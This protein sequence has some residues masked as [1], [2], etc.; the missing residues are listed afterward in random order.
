MR[1]PKRLFGPAYLTTSPAT[2]YGP[3]ASGRRAIVRFIQ[4]QVNSG[5]SS[6]FRLSIGADAAGTR[7]Y[8]SLTVFAIDPL[9]EFTYHVL[10]AG[11]FIQGSAGNATAL[12][13]CLEG[14]EIVLT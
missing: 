9:R 7:I 11:E 6:T 2:I 8:D 12:V 1:I 14:E 3:V 4:A 13:M 5:A 10:E